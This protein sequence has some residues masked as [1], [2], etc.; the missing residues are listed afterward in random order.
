MKKNLNSAAT[1]GVVVGNP[2]YPTEVSALVAT[3]ESA[4]AAMQA[5]T[6]LSMSASA[7]SAGAGAE[8]AAIAGAA[9]RGWPLGVTQS[10]RF[11]RA[12]CASVSLS[13]YRV[14]PR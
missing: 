7:E 3:R 1:A 12:E 13:R 9:A 6:H 11:H 10:A 14:R 4:I 8:F 5:S 2:A